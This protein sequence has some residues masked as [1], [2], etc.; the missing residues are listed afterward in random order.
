[1]HHGTSVDQ[2]HAALR[3]SILRGA[4]EPGSRL[5]LSRLAAEHGVSFIPVREALQRL[6]AERM[7]RIEPNRGATVTEISIADMTDIYETRLVLEEH[8][9]RQ[10][11]AHIT[12]E[13]LSD[14]EAALADMRAGFDRGDEPAAYQAHER[15][16]FRLYEV[17][18]SP[19][20]DH[21][22]HLLWSSAERYVRLSAGVRPDP[23]AFVAEHEE[24]LDA[25]VKGDA[26]LA[27]ARLAE[28]LRTTER[29]LAATYANADPEAY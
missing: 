21:I 9:I 20:T 7:V 25:V 18:E 22:L 1:M 13:A 10:A 16:H 6:E 26:D 24:I 8:A 17:A 3:E 19:W 11:V 23:D 4:Y 2:V 29:L 5:I 12:P 28:N 15:F 14:A 27:A